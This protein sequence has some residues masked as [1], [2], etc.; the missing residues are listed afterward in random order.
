MRSVIPS[1][2]AHQSEYT[3]E[4]DKRRQWMSKYVT[5]RFLTRPFLPM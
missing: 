2:D 3:A 4:G 5:P 1:E